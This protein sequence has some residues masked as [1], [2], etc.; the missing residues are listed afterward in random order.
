MTPLANFSQA[1]HL[2][3]ALTALWFLIFKLGHEYRL[4]A[5]RDRLFALRERL[6]DLAAN[7]E[8]AFDHTGYT[9]LRTLINGLIRFAHRLTFTRFL[10]GISFMRW[11]GQEYDKAYFT[12]WQDAIAEL[13]QAVRAELE[14]I[15]D[16]A[17]VMV[18]RHLVSGSPIMLA[19]L[20]VFA[21]WSLAT[22]LTKQLL[23]AFTK[24]LP[25]LDIL[26]IQVIEADAEE[27]HPERAFAHQ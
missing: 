26:Q 10:L 9:K 18:V 22:G 24:R 27:R 21:I 14:A 13:P 6:F 20:G 19:L 7:E 1:L 15:H 23:Q 4:D 17:L 25:G 12:E 11:K 16:E 5:L 2:L 8:I 3:L